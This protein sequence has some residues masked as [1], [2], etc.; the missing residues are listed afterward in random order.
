[1][2]STQ[3]AFAHCRPGGALLNVEQL[4]LDYE[5]LVH[6]HAAV[7]IQRTARVSTFGWRPVNH[8]KGTVSECSTG[9]AAAVGGANDEGRVAQQHLR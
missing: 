8:D 7:L 3:W 6:H 5:R 4:L 9:G 2:T 1:M